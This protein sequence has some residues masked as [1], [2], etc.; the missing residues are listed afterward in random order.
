MEGKNLQ[1][2]LI[3]HLKILTNLLLYSKYRMSSI[4]GKKL[5]FSAEVKK[6]CIHNMTEIEKKAVGF[7]VICHLVVTEFA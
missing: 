1:N 7:P 4:E 3:A 2:C 5:K 6:G